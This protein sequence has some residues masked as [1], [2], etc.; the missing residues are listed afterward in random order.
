MSDC[1]A[2]LS[3]SAPCLPD[4]TTLPIVRIAPR[5]ARP[6]PRRTRPVL[7]G[8]AASGLYHLALLALV[9]WLPATHY[10]S[11][12]NLSGRPSARTLTLIP[13]TETVDTVEE[14]RSV[15]FDTRAVENLPSNFQSTPSALTPPALPAVRAQMPLPFSRESDILLDADHGT[16]EP[17]ARSL[18][19]R[20][21]PPVP[22][23]TSLEMPLTGPRRKRSSPLPRAL[24]KPPPTAVFVE[25]VSARPLDNPSPR[26]PAEAMRR[27][28]EG[29]V[30]LR[31]AVSADGRVSR[32]DV[33]QSAG[34]AILDEAAVDAARHWIFEPAR[35]QG[36]R[37]ASCVTLPVRFV[38]H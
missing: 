21:R 5:R 35:R 19:A 25:T 28:I 23:S 1:P 3:V 4:S 16:R 20:A 33:V 27:G 12:A 37:V 38:L 32:V 11:I 18:V 22:K 24:S 2:T 26:F 9:V 30:V 13:P 10:A 29:R 7:L 15:V 6:L 36:N 34:Y 17:A 14:A 31:L 8:W